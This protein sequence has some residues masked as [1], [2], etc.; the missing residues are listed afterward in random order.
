MVLPR[1]L[2]PMALARA[3]K[4][5]DQGGEGV[6]GRGL[7]FAVGARAGPGGQPG[8]HT[9]SASSRQL[10]QRALPEAAAPGE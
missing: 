9:D 7:M 3:G 5:G 1:A 6:P 10:R 4:L 8:H 2:V